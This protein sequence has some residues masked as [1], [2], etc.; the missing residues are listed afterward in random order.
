MVVTTGSHK[1][2][3]V[4]RNGASN[5]VFTLVDDIYAEGPSLS[6]PANNAV[7][8]VN[9]VTGRAADVIFTWPRLSKSTAYGLEISYDNGF[10]EDVTTVTVTSSGSTVVQAVGPFQTA[11]SA[12]QV[13]LQPGT[14]YYWRVRTTSPIKSPYSETRMFTIASIDEPFSIKGP[15]AGAGNVGVS[16]LMT[17]DEYP[18]ATGYELALSE[19]PSF[20][21]VEWVRNVANNFYSVPEVLDY[22]TTYYWRVRAVTGTG[23]ADRGPWVTGVFQTMEEPAGPPATVTAPPAPEKTVI[24]TEQAPATIIEVPTTVTTPTPIPDY[25]LWL[26]IIIGAVLVIALIV[27]IV[28]TRR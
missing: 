11:G 5:N 10:R 3:V 19:D 14:T 13:E 7:G 2:W 26:I 18:G 9:P 20:A 16:P 15:V 24:I 22:S 6:A 1:L 17:W 4:D 28:R 27:L 12:Q 25:L 8:V 23:A 21:I